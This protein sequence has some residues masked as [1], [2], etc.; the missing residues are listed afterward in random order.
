MNIKFNITEINFI[1]SM[2][3]CDNNL[4]KQTKHLHG[5]KKFQNVETSTNFKKFKMIFYY[6]KVKIIQL[7]FTMVLICW[8]NLWI[9][10]IVLKQHY[11]RISKWKIK[12]K[13]YLS[14][15]NLNKNKQRNKYSSTWNSLKTRLTTIPM[16]IVSRQPMA[17]YQRN[18][19]SYILSMPELQI[20]IIGDEINNLI[21]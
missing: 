3:L 15:K 13:T 21:H 8:L 18:E 14:L 2:L 6:F 17:L 4:Q 5:C 9:D 12:N 19:I 11:Q 16:K 7:P 10:W 20:T 1:S